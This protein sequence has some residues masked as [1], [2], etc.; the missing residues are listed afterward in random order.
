MLCPRAAP[1]AKAF[2]R[3]PE[4]SDEERIGVVNPVSARYPTQLVS[5]SRYGYLLSTPLAWIPREAPLNLDFGEDGSDASTA[6]LVSLGADDFARRFAVRASGVMWLLGAGASASAGIPTADDMIWE[7]KQRL[8]VSQRRVEPRAVADLSNPAVRSRLQHHLDESGTFPPAGT[9]DEYAALFEAVYSAEA[10]RRA[11]IDSKIAGARPSYGHLALATLMHAGHARLLWT[12]NFDPLLADAAARVYGSTGALAT[13]ALDAPDLASQLV[14]DERWPIEIKLHGDFRSRRLKNTT[15]ELRHQDALLRRILVD[16]CRRYGMIVVGYSGRDD[17]IMDALEEALEAGSS[18]PRGLFWLHR[19]DGPPLPRVRAL[20][21]R[22]AAARVE[23]AIVEVEN[24][25]ETLRDVVRLID[26]LDTRAL[27]EFAKDRRRWT[28]A[29]RPNGRRAWPVVRLN[30]LPIT[31]M[32][33]VCRRV[34]CSIGGYSEIRD[35]VARAGVDIIFSRVR[36]GVLV[37]GEDAH[38]CAAFDDFNVVDF[39]LH[40]IELQ[41]LRYE[42]GERALL[43]EALSR[44]ITRTEGVQHLRRRSTDLLYPN[45]PSDSDW[46]PLGDLVGALAGTVD[47]HPELTWTEGVGTRL[48][49]ADDRL[50]LLVEP[51]VVF[52]G[53]TPTNKSAAADFARERT[54]KRYNRHLNE[55]VGFWAE[56]LACSGRQ[57]C[58]FDLSNGVDAA[59]RLTSATAYSRRL[60]A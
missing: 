20:L 42:S 7:F 55:L 49:W 53:I 51:R 59:F 25:D 30:A 5:S 16:C 40:V 26:D 52:E 32:P 57:L 10:D 21:T 17:T 45:N 12:T 11:Y 56:R 44:A 39:D 43:R 15:D 4:A 28:G 18:Y 3:S 22:A 31:E 33:T 35:A 14:N 41:R 54:V 29:P 37:F 19:G 36:A 24:F 34:T 23:A 60:V 47:G 27:D 46:R 8:Y 38:V 9:P 13:V 2:F 48:D 50:W 1:L 6:G 58:A